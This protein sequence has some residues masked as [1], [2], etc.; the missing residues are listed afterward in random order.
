V[1][2][3]TE[4]VSSENAVEI[5]S[6]SKRFK[7]PPGNNARTLKH[8]GLPDRTTKP[9]VALDDVS[10]SVKRGE[11]FG[12]IGRNGSGKS[13]LLRII[14]DLTKA[15]SGAI[16]R[17]G[18]IG[19]I[20]SLGAGLD[21]DLTAAENA[22]SA[23][24]LAGVPKNQA[25]ELIGPIAKW[26][27]LEDSMGEPVRTFSDGMKLRLAFSAAVHAATDIFVVDEAL[28][29]G[30]GRFQEKCLQR[31]EQLKRD[32]KTIIVISHSLSHVQRL[33]DRTAWLDM[34]KLIAVGDTTEVLSRY[35][36]RDID[37]ASRPEVHDEGAKVGD[38]SVIEIV[39]VRLAKLNP[40][41]IISGSRVKIRVDFLTKKPVRNVNAFISVHA[42]SQT[43]R[44]IDLHTLLPALGAEGRSE[45]GSIEVEISNL[46]LSA[47][48]YWIDT[49]FMDEGY[50]K[51]YDTRWQALGFTVEGPASPGPYLPAHGWSLKRENTDEIDGA[52]R[53][54]NSPKQTRPA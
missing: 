24:I 51:M 21:L 25:P 18:T 54:G 10:F 31:L 53:T 50:V 34:G 47:G 1:K 40:D 9:L 20:F 38:N 35:S 8:L 17:Q 4:E 14:A 11:C 28:A 27:E 3:P 12:L 30:D 43:Y 13:T 2:T 49:G 29:A 32:G 15:S 22:E 45:R 33:C 48:K 5:Q 44:P 6:V 46:D 36:A 23:V 52:G 37:E 7:R 19:G 41:E 39:N 42:D 26:A 16:Q